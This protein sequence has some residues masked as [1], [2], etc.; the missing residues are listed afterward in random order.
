MVSDLSVSIIICTCNRAAS[1]Q[2]TLESLGK[3]KIPSG[4]QVE[5]IVVDNGSTDETSMV[6]HRA[7]L[8]NM[9][10]QY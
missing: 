9:L 3:V 8:T 1:L 6:V 4:W 7:A 2:P 5:V 10:V